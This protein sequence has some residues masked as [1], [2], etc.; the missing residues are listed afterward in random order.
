[1]SQK[2]LWR[3]S[4]KRVDFGGAGTLKVEKRLQRGAKFH[5]GTYTP[6]IVK[7]DSQNGGQMEPKPSKGV[8]KRGPENSPKIAPKMCGNWVP[9]APPKWTNIVN[10]SIKKESRKQ[11]LSPEGPWGDPGAPKGPKRTISGRFSGD[12]L[13]I[14]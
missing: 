2:T 10:K 3:G 7:N 6:K 1:M 14:R 13:M 12:V 4:R 5:F 9:K 11:A 8:P